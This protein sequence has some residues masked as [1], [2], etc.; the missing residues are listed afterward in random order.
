MSG[1]FT[2]DTRQTGERNEAF[3]SRLQPITTQM[4]TLGFAARLSPSIMFSLLTGPARLALNE[5]KL[6]SLSLDEMVD[7]VRKEVLFGGKIKDRRL[8]KWN[9]VSFQ[10]FCKLTDDEEKTFRKCIKFVTE[11]QKDIPKHTLHK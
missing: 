5:L 10:D 4:E 8:T 9:N 6:Q 3:N 11:Y 1:L 7:D 2:G